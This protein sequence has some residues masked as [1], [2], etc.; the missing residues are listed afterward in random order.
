MDFSRPYRCRIESRQKKIETYDKYEQKNVFYRKSH[1]S[2]FDVENLHFRHKI[3]E[4]HGK[5]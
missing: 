5:S 2:I 3:N 4:N 1:F